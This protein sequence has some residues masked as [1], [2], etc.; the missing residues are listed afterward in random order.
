MHGCSGVAG[1]L[2]MIFELVG[3]FTDVLEGVNFDYSLI[4]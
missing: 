2:E 3:I 1:M 4:Y